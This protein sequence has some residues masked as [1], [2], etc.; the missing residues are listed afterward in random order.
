MV[1]A[2][3]EGSFLFGVVGLPSPPLRN[4]PMM[5]TMMAIMITVPIELLGC[6]GVVG[7]CVV[8][9]SAVGAGQVGQSPVVGCRILVQ[10]GQVFIFVI[11]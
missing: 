7:I 10:C 3:W 4:A 1:M 8:W 11:L 5:M 9:G 2:Y 6:V